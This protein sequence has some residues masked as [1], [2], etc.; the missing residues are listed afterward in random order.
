VTYDGAEQGSVDQS[1]EIA[2]QVPSPAMLGVV[3]VSMYWL[4]TWPHSIEFRTHDS[5]FI[6]LATQRV[7]LSLITEDTEAQ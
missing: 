3:I 7:V 2:G 5:S 4:L 6:F 1:E